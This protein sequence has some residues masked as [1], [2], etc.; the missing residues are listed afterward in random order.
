MYFYAKSGRS[1]R[2]R[3][4]QMHIKKTG[5]LVDPA[6]SLDRGAEG[7][8]VG[9]ERN[10]VALSIPA[11]RRSVVVSD[12]SS[13]QVYEFDCVFHFLFPFPFGDYIIP[14]SGHVVKG[15]FKNFLFFL[16]K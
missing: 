7:F 13:R 3:P 9:L 1:P 14:Q 6:Q 2:V 12:L 10:L 5:S 15:F 8:G 11:H 4:A 16:E